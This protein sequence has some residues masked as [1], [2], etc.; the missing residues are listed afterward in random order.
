M[1]DLTEPSHS[2]RSAG[3]SCPYAASSACA[4]IGSP[5]TV[6]VPCASTTSTWDGVTEASASACSM[7]RCWEGPLGAVRPLL[8]PS[9]FTAE[10][11]STAS[12]R[13][14]FRRASE[15]RSTSRTPAP[16][17]NP[18]PSAAAANALQRPSCASPPCALKLLNMPGVDMTVTPPASASV[19]SPRRRACAA[20]CR[21][22]SDEEQAV[23]TVTAGPSRPSV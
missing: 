21:A 8:A 14:P 16:S 4:S 3:R 9:W 7:T 6:P 12:T 5:S 10:P 20:R 18:V 15:S 19:H 1:F 13:C 11:R 2:G 17:A 23:S 22:T